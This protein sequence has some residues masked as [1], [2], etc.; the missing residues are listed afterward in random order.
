MSY[1]GD[2]DAGD[3]I[4]FKF[5]TVNTS[6][7]PTALS[8]GFT[9]AYKD[10][11]TTQTLTGVTLTASFDSLTGLNHIA[12]DTSQDSSFY[13]AGSDFQLVMVSGTVD[14]SSI[15]GYEIG[16]FSLRNRAH[17]Y[18]VVAGRQLAISTGSHAGIDWANIGSPSTA[19]NLSATNIDVDQVVASVSGNVVGS[20]GSVAAGGITASSIATDAIDAD[21]L[22]ADAVTEIQ[23]GLATAANQTTIL[24]RLG[25]FTG[26]GVN[27]IL[28][29]FQALMRSDATT[30]SDLGGTYD[31]ATDSLQALRDNVGTNGAALVLAKTTNITGFNDLDAAGVR[32]AVGLAS[33]NLDTQLGDL[34]TAAEN[35]D[36]V[37]DEILSGHLG[38][39]STGEALNA[40]G[41]AGDPWT[42]ALPG[43]YGAGSAG[44]IIG[45]NLN[46]TV[47]S[48]ATQ[49]S[50]DTIDTNVDSILADTGTDGVVVAAGSKTGYTLSAAGV[51]AIW[52]ALT[53][54]LTTAGSIG[55]LLADNVNATISSRSSHS[56][57]DVWSVATRVLTAG[58]NIVLA[59]GT[60]VTG[61]NDLSA[62]Q[63]NAEVV[64]ALA[65][66]TYAEPGQGAPAATATLA[67]K[68]GFIYKSFRNRKT[69]DA[70]TLKLYGDDGT[71][72]DQKA[73]ISDDG[74]VYTHGE[75]GTGP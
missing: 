73:T 62:A 64:D 58:T 51:Q 2:F 9:A 36:A 66:D 10:G 3:T 6:G 55:K 7:V 11:S 35:A 69:Q 44:N 18:P 5:T 28:G 25:T 30:P 40:A 22:A 37:W 29:F 26:T 70:T 13:A 61:F 67:T 49:T 15:A 17:L 38:A 60:G 31:D 72:V 48:R 56:A 33:A 75:L 8:G 54:A 59:K 4:Y 12:V 52:D 34:P 20:V 39:G 63:V 50:V 21:A 27:T 42:T 43:A 57:A 46:A 24:N 74:T 16:A 71:T 32:A 65:T 41:A 14:G 1:L 53:S 45:N 23:S 47:S 19:Q 68:I